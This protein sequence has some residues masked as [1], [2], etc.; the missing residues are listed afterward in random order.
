MINEYVAV[1]NHQCGGNEALRD[2]PIDDSKNSM[3]ELTG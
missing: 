3:G 2:F 1:V